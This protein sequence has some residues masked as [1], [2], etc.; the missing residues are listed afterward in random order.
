MTVPVAHA[1][2]WLVETL[3]IAPVVVIVTWISIKALLDRRRE[4]RQP[5]G[6]PP[7]PAS[8]ESP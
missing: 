7:P 6:E 2:H 3:Y 5:A 1:G 8:P 4:K